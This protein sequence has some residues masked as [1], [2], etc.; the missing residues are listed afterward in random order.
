M[1]VVR[2]TEKICDLIDMKESIVQILEIG[3]NNVAEITCAL[4]L[5]DFLIDPYVAF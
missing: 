1:L 2:G 3:L 5:L 4:I